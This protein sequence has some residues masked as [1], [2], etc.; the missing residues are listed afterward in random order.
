MNN[1]KKLG[2]TALAG[3]LVAVNANAGE[4]SVSG[5][6]NATYVTTDGTT[7]TAAAD[8]G[9]GLGNDKDFGVSGSGELDNGWTF[10]G[11]TAMKEASG[12]DI[13]TSALS[14]TMGS[15]GTLTTG[16]QFGGSSTKYDEQTPKAYEEIDDMGGTTLS[17]N[18]VGSWLD[19]NSLVYN[20]PSMDMGGMSVSFDV[21]YT[22]E[23]S[24]SSPNDGGLQHNT[25]YNSG[26]SLGIT[27]SGSGLTVGVYGAER[28]NDGGTARD[29]DAFEGV[30]YANYSMGPV[31]VGFSQS[32]HDSGQFVAA[33]SVGA[34]K[35]VNT[36]GGI[37]ETEM[38]SIAFNINDNMSVSYGKATDTY[39]AQS[40]V[41]GGTE[42]L[43]VEMELKS[44]QMSYTM[45]SMSINAQRTETD[46]VK[47]DT[48]G[49]SQTK[50]EI[51]L[52]LAF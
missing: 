11:N 7:G 38:F 1:L 14:L 29:K 44:I 19:N 39:D 4:L 43:D 10:A 47:Y 15:L 46:N 23:A 27:A 28:D 34:A 41:K 50:T 9:I 30:W 37:F 18:I 25:E 33:E 21:E 52:G 26:Q 13:S 42:I 48:N 17:A 45:G 49:G 40:N 6:F 32:Y 8:H 51:A 2:L 12:F 22:P 3:S 16:S 35:V 31:S 36:A 5:G 24:G 20:S